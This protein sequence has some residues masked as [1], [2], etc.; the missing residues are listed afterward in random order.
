MIDTRSIQT[1]A[2]FALDL[3]DLAASVALD[4]EQRRVLETLAGSIQAAL[5]AISAPADR[6][7]AAQVA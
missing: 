4:D 6:A 5:D 2:G 3:E 7:A 1:L